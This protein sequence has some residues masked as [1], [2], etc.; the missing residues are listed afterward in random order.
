MDFRP[1]PEPP[2]AR[3]APRARGPWRGLRTLVGLWALGFAL[4]FV[5]PARCDERV[6]VGGLLD[7]EFWKTDDG[8][9]L[10]SRNEGEAAP[11]ARLRLWAASEFLPRLQGFVLE[12]VQSGRARDTG[13]TPQELEQAYLRSSFPAPLRLIGEAGPLVSP[14]GDL[15]RRHLSRLNPPLRA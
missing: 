5:S 14:P 7:A 9:R 15:S 8:S 4:L 10:L 2:G 11:A 12:E 1:R 13:G 3:P 6:L